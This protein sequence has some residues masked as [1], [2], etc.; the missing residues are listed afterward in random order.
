MRQ[1]PPPRPSPS[2]ACC[3]PHARGRVGGVLH[4][5]DQLVVRCR[6]AQ[7]RH[8]SILRVGHVSRVSCACVARVC[9]GGGMCRV[10]RAGSASRAVC[11]GVVSCR[12]CP[13]TQA[14][15]RACCACCARGLDHHTPPRHPPHLP[16]WQHVGHVGGQEGQVG[17]PAR[18]GPQRSLVHDCNN[19]ALH[20]LWGVVGSVCVCAC[21]CVCV[22]VVWWGGGGGGG[23]GGGGGGGRVCGGGGGAGRG[24]QGRH[25][26]VEVVRRVR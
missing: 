17:A 8:L 13:Q 23:V 2:G 20:L 16:V 1:R 6:P 10:A 11:T 18:L 26:V 24:R 12:S 21:V 19:Q 25:L 5:P 22:C 4:P 7:L 9:M 14:G 15:C 3:A